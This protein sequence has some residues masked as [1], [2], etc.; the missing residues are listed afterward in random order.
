MGTVKVVLQVLGTIFLFAG[1]FGKNIP[2]TDS[3]GLG[4]GLWALSFF[5]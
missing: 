1:G 3:V 2:G 5:L 4:A